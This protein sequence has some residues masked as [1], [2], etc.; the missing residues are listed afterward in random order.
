MVIEAF[1]REGD[2]VLD[3]FAGF[4][5]TALVAVAMGRRTVAVE[6]LEDRAAIIRR[7]LGS[8]PAGATVVVGD[9]R[10]LSRIVAGP[11]DLCATSPPYMSSVG[12]PEN[13]L[14]GY[15]TR[16]AE[17][18]TYLAELEDVFRQVAGLLRPGGHLV[19]NVADVVNEGR[20][21]PLASDLRARIGPHLPFRE[22]IAIDWDVPPPGVAN[23]RLLVFEGRMARPRVSRSWRPGP[24]AG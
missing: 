19:V 16:D 17:Y 14:T 12:H 5:T 2:L 1:S 6:L 22:E 18:A 21:T 20:I 7:R 3:P 13:P 23:D 24:A 4:G 9:A 11:V 10:E 15:R 8:H